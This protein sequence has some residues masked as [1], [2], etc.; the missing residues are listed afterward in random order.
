VFVSFWLAF[1]AYILMAWYD[2][3][4]DC[5]DRFGPTFLGYL[6]MAFKPAEYREKYEA[7]PVKYQKLVR[8]VDL[9][10]LGAAILAL[11]VPF[12]IKK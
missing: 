1:A 6:S 5:T 3:L 4:Y 10:I 2:Y 11:L 7:L 12:I 9:F 8:D